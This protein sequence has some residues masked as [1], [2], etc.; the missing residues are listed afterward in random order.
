[1]QRHDAHYAAIEAEGQR[2]VIADME[3]QVCQGIPPQYH[4]VAIQNLSLAMARKYQ[5]RA[6]RKDSAEQDLE[7]AANYIHRAQ[8]GR[9]PWEQA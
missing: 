6:G 5:R 4:A 2:P 8:T 3:A 7:K 9:W 1:M